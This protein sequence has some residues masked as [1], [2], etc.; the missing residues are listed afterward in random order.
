[1]KYRIIN[2]H[3]YKFCFEVQYKPFKLF[4]WIKIEVFNNL[5]KARKF[6]QEI[7]EGERDKCGDKITLVLE[8]YEI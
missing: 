6:I 2:S 1:M 3:K 4:G 8:E 7:R 5:E